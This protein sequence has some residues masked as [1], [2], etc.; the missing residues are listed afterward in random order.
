MDSSESMDKVLLSI[1]EA[2]SCEDL[3]RYLKRFLQE[4]ELSS[5]LKLYRDFDTILNNMFLEYPHDIDSDSG[6][7]FELPNHVYLALA[8]LSIAI[9]DI[10]IHRF[11]LRF[12]RMFRAKFLNNLDDDSIARF[13][14][15]IGVRLEYSGSKCFKEIQSSIT[16]NDSILTICYRYRIP[17]VDYLRAAKKMFTEQPWKLSSVILGR[18]Y[19]YLETRDKV[20]RLLSEQIYNV[21]STKLRN[22]RNLCESRDKLEEMLFNVLRDYDQELAEAIKRFTQNLLN[23]EIASVKQSTNLSENLGTKILLEEISKISSIEQL[24]AISQKIFPPCIRDLIEAILRGENLSHHQR[25]AIATFLINLGVDLE[26]VVKLFSHSPDFNE[27][28]S[29]YQVEH[30]AGLRGSRKKYLIYSCNTMKTLGMCKAEC[31]VKNPLLYLRKVLVS[32]KR[33]QEAEYRDSTTSS[34]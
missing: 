14:R 22:I 31:G 29:R 30:L 21:L 8:L 16:K 26:I 1:L 6:D 23:L 17:I 2:Q 13:S 19:V 27:K 5:L 24:V 20:L 33:L 4:V 18:G 9:G 15:R 25:F 32:S 3:F 10:Y 28:I 34:N 12:S 7:L 11:A